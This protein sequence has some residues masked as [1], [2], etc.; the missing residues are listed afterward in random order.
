MDQPKPFDRRTGQRTP[1]TEPVEVRLRL[2]T[3]SRFTTIPALV[4]DSTFSGLGVELR[5][6][7]LPGAKILLTAP[8]TAEPT[9][10]PFPSEGRVVWCKPL[11][12]GRFR[13]GIHFERTPQTA[14]THNGS[15]E[16]RPVIASPQPM[17]VTPPEL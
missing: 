6:P 12:D 2:E 14:E 5:Q 9:Y 3:A 1:R 15:S 4:L 8:P 11:G 7:I 17:G 10:Q 13:A 16:L